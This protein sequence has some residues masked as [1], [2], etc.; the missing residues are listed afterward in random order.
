[1]STDV[2]QPARDWKAARDQ[3]RHRRKVLVDAVKAAHDGGMSEYEL[4]RQVG[5]G[6]GTIR[7]WLGKDQ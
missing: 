7:E 3:V 5:V 4:A 1:M 6:R 2:T